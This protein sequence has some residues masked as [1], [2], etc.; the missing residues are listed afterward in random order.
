MFL[1]IFCYA[2]V[3]D[4]NADPST[5]PTASTAPSDAEAIC[6]MVLGP[7]FSP[8]FS[9]GFPGPGFSLASASFGVIDSGLGSDSDEDEEFVPE[10][11]LVEGPDSDDSD[12]SDPSTGFAADSNTGFSDLAFDLASDLAPTNCGTGASTPFF[13]S[14]SGIGLAASNAVIKSFGISF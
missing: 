12:N 4:F 11:E 6:S 13:A 9:P 1:L 8:G 10:E 5:E 3:N 2:S 14:S 7:G